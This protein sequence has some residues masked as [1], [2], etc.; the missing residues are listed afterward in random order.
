MARTTS[1]V[2]GDELDGFIREQVDK[3]AYGNAS[4]VVRDALER[5]ADQKR[6]EEWLHAELDK[7]LKSSR[8]PDGVFDRVLERIRA[9]A[10]ADKAHGGR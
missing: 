9:R 1:Y 10:A 2:L 5:L 6:K 4:D 8:A 3:G 7:G